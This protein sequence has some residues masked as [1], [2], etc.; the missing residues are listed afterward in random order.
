MIPLRK[1]LHV[2][3][4][5]TAKEVLSLLEK[6]DIDGVPVLKEGKY[7]G[8]VTRY[9]L[10]EAQFLSGMAT[11]D[12]LNY[13]KAGDIAHWKDDSINEDAVF[14][15]TLLL[16]K[17]RPLIAVTGK[18]GDLLGIITRS[19]I[20]SQFQSAFGMNVKGVRIS[21]TSVETEGRIARLSEITRQFH[22]NII[23]LATFDETDKL[24]RRIV[25]KVE[26][27]QNMDKF[28]KKLE[29]SGFRILSI[30]ED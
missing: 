4:N 13:V 9:K 14:E 19:D 11:D 8:I 24:V 20:L 27:K 7:A 23:S 10:F 28:L 5:R 12:F 25:M 26:K 16:V 3:E 18:T 29:Q 1:T 15:K 22:E 17:D 2:Q 30:H 21:F 6:H